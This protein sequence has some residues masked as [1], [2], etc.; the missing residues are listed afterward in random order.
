[1]KF[2][3]VKMTDSRGFGKVNHTKKSTCEDGDGEGEGDD[4]DV[5]CW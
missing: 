3:Q 2:M 5:E 1:M 4:G